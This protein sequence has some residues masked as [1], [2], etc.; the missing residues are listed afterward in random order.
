MGLAALRGE[1]LGRTERPATVLIH[2]LPIGDGVDS[3][4]LPVHARR[5]VLHIHGDARL[6]G[7]GNNFIGRRTV[8]AVG[9]RDH[10]DR[11]AAL[12]IEASEVVAGG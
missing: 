9:H 7:S 4:Q 2:D 10:A 3:G 6:E 5:K 1:P 8:Y 11:V 12:R